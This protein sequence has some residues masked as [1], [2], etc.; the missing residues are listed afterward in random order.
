MHL[1]MLIAFGLLIWRIDQQ[2]FPPPLESGT[3]SLMVA[4]GQLPLWWAVA[5]AWSAYAHRRLQG[6]VNGVEAAQITYHRSALV[7]RLL[8]F[9]GFAA[10]LFL[11]R[12]PA[13][14]ERL[15]YLPPWSALEDLIVISPFLVGLVLVWHALFPIDRALR[16]HII[17]L[18]KWDGMYRAR[19]WTLGEYLSFNLRHQILIIAVPMMLILVTYRLCGYH[20]SHL[21][22]AL[23]FS[24]APDALLGVV[25]VAVFVVSPVLLKSIW[26]TSPLKD[27]P[28]RRRLEQ[29]CQRLGLRCRDILV[30]DSHGM[31]INAAVMG[32]VAPLRYVLLS[33]GLLEG[34]SE[35]EIEAV[36]GHEAGHVRHHHVPYF[37]LFA[38]LSILVVSGMMEVVV[39]LGRR[40]DP[41]FRLGDTALQGLGLGLM[42]VVW[43]VAFGWLSR[44]FERQADVCGAHCVTPAGTCGAACGVHPADGQSP[45]PGHAVCVTGAKVF[46][47]ALDRVALLNGI[48]HEE[49]SW[50][51]SSIASRMRF[52]IAQAGDPA[53]ARAFQ[54]LITNTKWT[55][56][57]AVV[58]GS[59]ITAA[60]CLWQP[61]YREFILQ[62]TL[63][64]LAI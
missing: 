37:L 14:I 17:H 12:W 20:R 32:V 27:G 5:R 22:H 45:G 58:G 62:N 7:L 51:H 19:V 36:F 41:V 1:L 50:R 21:T 63:A 60:Y 48:P 23:L 54:R 8:V 31:M 10:D 4:I 13:L 24:W 47:G 30:W 28:L 59:I 38:V 46:V 16:K 56:W 29:A 52:L 61:D 15:P 39:R 33:D 49:R 6:P 64:P 9:V 25:A 40:P 44:R 11:T 26:T 2:P 34:L 3:W 42:V 18:R 53:T 57:T 43:G 55:L 35:E